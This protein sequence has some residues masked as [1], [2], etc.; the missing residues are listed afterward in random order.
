MDCG[1]LVLYTIPPSQPAAAMFVS[2]SAAVETDADAADA[3]EF[4]GVVVGVVTVGGTPVEDAIRLF[5]GV[6]GTGAPEVL[7]ALVVDDVDDDADDD[8]EEEDS[9]DASGR[10]TADGLL[11]GKLLLLLTLLLATT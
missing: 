8:S 1:W 7:L 2:I 5:V 4:C 11:L 9:D 3:A 6:T 10:D